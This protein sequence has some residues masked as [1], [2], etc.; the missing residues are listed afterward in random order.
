[1]IHTAVIVTS[2]IVITSMTILMHRNAF[3]G[4]WVRSK[5]REE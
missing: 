5:A 1:M 2:I 3:P 4:Q